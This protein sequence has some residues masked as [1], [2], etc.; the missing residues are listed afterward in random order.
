MTRYRFA[1][2]LDSHKPSEKLLHETI[3]KLKADRQFASA[4]RDGLRLIVDLRAGGTE[5]LLELFPGIRERLNRQ[6]DDLNRQHDL[7]RQID[8]LEEILKG[9]GRHHHIH[10]IRKEIE[11]LKELLEGQGSKPDAPAGGGTGGEGNGGGGIRP[12]KTPA[13]AMPLMPVFDDDSDTI[14]ITKS[15]STEASQNLL[16][17]MSNLF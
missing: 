11:E 2:W 4:I 15:T 9:Q 8:A 7:S 16:K 5:V 13:L 12:L 14:I 6:H 17:S 1:F 3:N 10:H